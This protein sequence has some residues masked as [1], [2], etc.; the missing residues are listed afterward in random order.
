M[1]NKLKK[2]KQ[3]KKVK[4]YKQHTKKTQKNILLDNILK[5]AE[6]VSINDLLN[7]S[8]FAKQKQKKNKKI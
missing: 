1:I 7:N 8:L 4:N 3:S 5:A 2:N 6:N